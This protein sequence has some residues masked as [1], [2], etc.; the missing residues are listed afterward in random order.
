MHLGE[1]YEIYREKS[2]LLQPL[3]WGGTMQRESDPKGR[4]SESED[5][6]L[7]IVVL[8]ALKAKKDTCKGS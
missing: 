5:C 2:A 3:C 8:C 6:F 4:E 1:G 7:N